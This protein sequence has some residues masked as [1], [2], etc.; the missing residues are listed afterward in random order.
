VDFTRWLDSCQEIGRAIDQLPANTFDNLT[1]Y[2]RKA[3]M[4]GQVEKSPV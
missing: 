1:F 3:K 4:G 2:L